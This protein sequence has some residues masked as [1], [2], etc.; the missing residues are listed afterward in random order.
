M[1]Q[2]IDAALGQAMTA[3]S[4]PGVMLGIWGPNGHYERAY[5][6]ADKA[7]KTPMQASFYSRIGSVTKTFTVT[8]VL[9]LADQGKVGLDD[10]I[11][12]YID[13]VPGGM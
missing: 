4:V 12:K 2:K 8:A 11:G 5:G 3:A 1:K 10:A 13:G 9:Q 6:F 7:I